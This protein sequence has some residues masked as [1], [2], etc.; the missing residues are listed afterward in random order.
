MYPFSNTILLW[1][2]TKLTCFFT[3]KPY[4]N[5]KTMKCPRCNAETSS[6]SLFCHKCGLS[7]ATKVGSQPGDETKDFSEDI[8][9]FFSAN[10]DF[11][12]RYKIIEEIGRGGMAR[13]Y[14]AEDKVLNTIVAL[15]M[16]RPEFLADSQ[17]IDRFKRELLM[18]REI[19]HENVVRIYDFG[20]VNGVK[21]IS[22]QYI[23]GKSLKNLIEESGPLPFE[24]IKEIAKKICRGLIAAHKK[25]VVH[26]DLKP[27]NIMIDK[28]N[29]VYITDFGLA[30][31]S[32]GPEKSQFGAVVGT[33]Q[34]IAPEQWLGEKVDNRADIYTLGIILYEMITGSQPFIADS[35]IGYFQK[36]LKEKPALHKTAGLKVPN[37]FKKIVKKCLEKKR[38]YRY[39]KVED[40]LSDIDA[41]IF[42]R[43]SISNWL[44]KN[45]VFKG[46]AA[47]I[48]VLLAVYGIYRIAESLTEEQ[49]SNEPVIERTLAVFPFQNHTGEKS[50]DPLRFTIST[51]LQADLEQSPFLKVLPED[52]LFHLLKDV[53][54]KDKFNYSPELYKKISLQAN[55]NYIINGNFSKLGEDLVI[56]VNIRNVRNDELI[57]IGIEYTVE[58]KI[59]AAIDKITLRIKEKLHF[60]TAEEKKDFKIDKDVETVTSK[61]KK[62][63]ALYVQGKIKFN[64]EMYVESI[65]FFKL[66]VE[67]DP[68]FAM[69]Y[70]DIA[71]AYANLNDLGKR[72]EY[73]K[74]AM[75]H[76]KNLPE[77][78]RLL[79]EGYFYGENERTYN[80]A[81][82]SL[83]KLLKIYPDNYE[84]NTKLGG[85]FKVT[86][87]WDKA[88]KYFKKA[89]DG[90]NLDYQA[91]AFLASVY[92]AK[93]K[94]D[95][96]REV[97]EKYHKTFPKKTR[98]LSLM[99][100]SY[101]IQK[102][103]IH[104]G[105]VREEID[106]INGDTKSRKGE[107]YFYE[108]EL[109]KAEKE[110]EKIKTDENE[111]FHKEKIKYLRLLYLLKG[112]FNKSIELL[113]GNIKLLKAF[114]Y[115]IIA[116]FELAHLY[117]RLNKPQ[118]ALIEIEKGMQEESEFILPY[119]H[120]MKQFYTG[121]AYLKLKQFDRVEVVLKELK[122]LID[123]SVS[124]RNIRY[125][126]FL[127]GRRERENKNYKQAIH[128]LE[129]AV[130]YLP[131]EVRND[132]GGNQ[133]AIFSYELA[134]T[135]YEAGKSDKARTRF[136]KIIGMT[137]GRVYFGD[138]YAKSFYYL[139][140]ILQEKGWNGKAIENYTKFLQLWQDLDPG[141]WDRM[142]QDAQKQRKILK[143]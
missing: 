30:I 124:K 36:H 50:H 10:D 126:Y 135:Y 56:K 9:F 111:G 101:I 76:G 87:E 89:A 45:R 114:E 137:F 42:S 127:Q 19:A 115:K 85:L 34:Y 67:E 73:F 97:I 132:F 139:G 90:K 143:P 8:S 20:E 32:E 74:K 92:M 65:R 134:V 27:H 106:K 100:D 80:K 62:A 40:L 122:K 21:F 38:E 123:D 11:G 63:R 113:R 3:G 84:A 41:G 60:S 120:M 69:A 58:N 79:I 95:E 91:Y 136:E 94:Y 22:M 29:H 133:Q 4:Q 112:K 88:I 57:P 118:E 121:L 66:A 96:A 61:S 49:P 93:D 104:A 26:R 68:E 98:L 17:M 105:I 107:M 81:L 55:V 18:A 99:Y 13:V 83:E 129:K 1:Y 28:K 15:K 44:R 6:D 51:L 59:P 33:P 110:F 102:D 71:W 70:K 16:I 78:E 75:E 131:A 24:K 5:F 116:V 130:K 142:K 77:K 109:G 140:K 35:D 25:G 103:F 23:E 7:L 82:A 52:Y 86:E 138:L 48:L 46:A 119:H 108:G 43:G 117:L 54:S 14:K 53:I 141:P 72:R 39:A 64:Q 37:Y 2:F 47:L 125:Y 31:T 12:S 128:N